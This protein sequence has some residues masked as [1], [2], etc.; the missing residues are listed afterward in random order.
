MEMLNQLYGQKQFR[1]LTTSERIDY[2][3]QLFLDK[4]YIANPQG[5]GENGEFDSAP[6]YRFDGFDCVTFVNNILALALSDDLHAFEKKLAEINYYDSEITFENRF[7]FMSVDWN[8]QNQKHNIIRDITNKMV[9]EKNHSKALVAEGEIDKPSWFLKK[10]DNETD[11]RKKLLIQ[12][13][14]KFKKEIAH[15]SYLP[16][17]ELFDSNN[18]PNEFIFNQIPSASI[19]E[20]VRPNWNLKDKIGTNLHVSHLGFAIRKNNQ[21]HFRHA[22]SEEKKVVEILLL[23][24]LKNMLNSPTIKGIHVETVC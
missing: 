9:D 18:N 5:E 6:F 19:I 8:L 12:Y 10:A 7:H 22:S 1:A 15:V 16:L 3:S 21:L 11:Q 17:T 14:E 13:A 20:I 4:P 24:Y 2:L 23:D